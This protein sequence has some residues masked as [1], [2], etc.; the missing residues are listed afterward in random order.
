MVAVVASVK[1]K[2]SHPLPMLPNY[3]IEKTVELTD[4]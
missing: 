2:I 3:S 1:D 4:F